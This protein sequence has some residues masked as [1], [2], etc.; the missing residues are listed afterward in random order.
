MDFISKTVA[1]VEGQPTSIK[2]LKNMSSCSTPKKT[3][4]DDLKAESWPSFNC[5]VN[6]R[7]QNQTRDREH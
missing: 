1:M 6:N 5:V 3:S 4:S 2:S 7:N